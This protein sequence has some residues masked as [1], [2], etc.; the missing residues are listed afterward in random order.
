M[1][2]RS[3]VAL[4]LM[5]GICTLVPTDASAKPKSTL[6]KSSSDSRINAVRNFRS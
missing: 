4:A 6:S 5:L 2:F 1:L 3:L